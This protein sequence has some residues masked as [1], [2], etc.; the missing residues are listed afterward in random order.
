MASTMIDSF[1]FI[2]ILFWFINKVF[3]FLRISGMPSVGLGMA[4]AFWGAN[5]KT[6]ATHTQHNFV[7]FPPAS[8]DYPLS[9]ER[10]SKRKTK[11][12]FLA[13]GRMDGQGKGKH[14]LVN[15]AYGISTQP[16]CAPGLEESVL[17]T[18]MVYGWMIRMGKH[19]FL[20]FFRHLI[21]R[22]AD[23]IPLNPTP[24]SQKQLYKTRASNRMQP[25]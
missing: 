10:E 22:R 1:F 19:F 21:D 4:L 13:I 9:K 7:Q 17:L 24:Q 16:I 6:E 2:I 25:E 20:F 14:G 23:Q 11:D 3:L 5:K 8:T 15:Q 12:T 18:W